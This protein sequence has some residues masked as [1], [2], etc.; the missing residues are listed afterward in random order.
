MNLKVYTVP[1]FVTEVRRGARGEIL[2]ENEVESTAK[3]RKKYGYNIVVRT[4]N[5]AA[6]HY[7]SFP[8]YKI[9]T[10]VPTFEKYMRPIPK[11]KLKD[12]RCLSIVC[13]SVKK[14]FINNKN[15]YPFC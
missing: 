7:Y 1:E 8:D 6:F 2:G 3:Y 14:L 11:S 10:V 13:G 15:L 12:N 5:D 9:E 4:M